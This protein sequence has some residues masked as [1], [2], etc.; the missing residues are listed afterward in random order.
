MICKHEEFQEIIDAESAL[1][2]HTKFNLTLGFVKPYF[3][4]E[5]KKY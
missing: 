4:A 2:Y 3:V 1:W 5:P